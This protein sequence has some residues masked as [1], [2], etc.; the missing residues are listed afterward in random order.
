MTRFGSAGRKYEI[1]PISLK[2]YSS[3]GV[4]YKKFMYFFGNPFFGIFV[5]EEITVVDFIVGN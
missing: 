3:S 2:I 5:L 1:Y 4:V